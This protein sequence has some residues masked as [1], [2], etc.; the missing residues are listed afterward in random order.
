MRL[1][2]VVAVVVLGLAPGTSTMVDDYSRVS[3]HAPSGTV[4]VSLDRDRVDTAVGARLTVTSHITNTGETP[5]D[6]L[7]AHLNVASLDGVYTDLEDWSAD[8]T[9]EV[10]PIGPGNRASLRWEF[11]AVNTGNFDVY[12]TVLPNGPAS[13][14]RGPLV[15]SPPM[16]VVVAG[17]RTLSAGGALPVVLVMPVL[18][19]AVASAAWLGRRRRIRAG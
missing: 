5:T 3:A 17:R 6:P 14:G 2:S 16:H 1:L 8:V 15:A 12:V 13:A 10:R 11:Q 19:G 9:R 4:E 7:V 18:V